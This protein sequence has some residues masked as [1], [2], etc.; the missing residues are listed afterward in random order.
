MKLSFD[1]RLAIVEHH[2]KGLARIGIEGVWVEYVRW[3]TTVIPH[4]PTHAIML[5]AIDDIERQRQR[6][7]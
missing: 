2:G 3:D 5:K 1:P 6:A 7:N 4:R